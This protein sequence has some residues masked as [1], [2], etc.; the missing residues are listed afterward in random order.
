MSELPFAGHP[1]IAAAHSVLS[2]YPEKADAS[3]LLQECGIGIVLVE[4]ISEP[5]GQLLRMTQAAPT[6]RDPGLE[7]ATVAKMLGCA[8]ADLAGT[9][10]EVV[11]TGVPWL[12]VELARFET[13]SA[14]QPDQGLIA[15]ECAALNAT[16][17]NVFVERNDGSAVRLRVRTLPQRAWQKILSAAPATDR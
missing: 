12:I 4:V 8:E 10:V 1:T 2:R 3:L 15:R 6:F 17:V 9:P 5:S 14:L 7:R 13:I 11:S 16:G